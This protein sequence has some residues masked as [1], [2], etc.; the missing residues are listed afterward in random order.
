VKARGNASPDGRPTASWTVRP[1]GQAGGRNGE[2]VMHLL[3]ICA[4]GSLARPICIG[5]LA[6]ALARVAPAHA[7]DQAR[8][9]E[10]DVPARAEDKGRALE[11]E[12]AAEDPTKIS[13]RVGVSYSGELSVSGSMAVGPKF[14]FN[15]RIAKSG[16]WSLGA[17]YLLPVAILTFAAGKS[18]LDSGV[19]QTRY[20]LGG[21]VPLARIGVSTGKWQLFVPFGYTYT[22]GKQAVTDLDQQDGIP[23]EISSNSAYVGIFT[24]RPLNER[25]TLM[26]GANFSKGTNDFS[27]VAAAGG[28]SY[29]LTGNDT[30]AVRTSYVANSFGHNTRIG[31]SFQHEF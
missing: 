4:K 11:R 18:E 24:I 1:A 22:N 17:S 25:L 10:P 5:M 31:I 27:G 2:A 9:P 20:S 14:K 28:L 8:A 29:H 3:Q 6:L 13:T 7:Q 16:Q 21:F 26:T 19:Q 12:K 30:V 15:G 23:I